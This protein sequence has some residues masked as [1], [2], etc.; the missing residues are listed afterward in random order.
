[1][2]TIIKDRQFHFYKKVQQLSSDDA[3]VKVVLEMCHLDSSMVDY[4]KKFNAKNC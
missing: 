3:I 2:T 4:Y 1:M